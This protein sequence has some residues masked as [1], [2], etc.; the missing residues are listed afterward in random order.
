MKDADPLSPPGHQI[1]GAGQL[2][3]LIHCF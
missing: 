2:S 3:S 1:L